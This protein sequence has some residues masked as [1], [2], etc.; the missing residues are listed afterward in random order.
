MLIAEPFA[1]VAQWQC[2]CL[3]SRAWGFDSPLPLQND[4]FRK[5][6]AHIVFIF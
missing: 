3:P 1:G 5:I 2:T 6:G 4:T